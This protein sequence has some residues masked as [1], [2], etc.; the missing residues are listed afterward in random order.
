[1]NGYTKKA[2][3]DVLNNA[4]V[5]SQ[6]PNYS[7]PL[8]NNRIIHLRNYARSLIQP[9]LDHLEEELLTAEELVWVFSCAALWVHAY[10][11]LKTDKLPMVPSTKE[12]FDKRS[13]TGLEGYSVKCPHCK[14]K[15][16]LE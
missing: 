11:I 6:Q 7:K 2:I 9:S 14:E 12:F 16:E 8:T 10:R 3:G 4:V 13:K 5:M 1:M 15:F